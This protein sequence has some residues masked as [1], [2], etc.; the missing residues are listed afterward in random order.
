MAYSLD[1]DITHSFPLPTPEE[2]LLQLPL[3]DQLAH[4]VQSSRHEVRD[5]LNGKSA[6]KLIIVG[7]CSV[8][9]PEAVL[10]YASRLHQLNKELSD[11]FFILM[12]VYCEK[13]RTNLAWKGFLYDP[14]LDGSNDLIFGL[15]VSRE[16]ML[17]ITQM[18]V[19]IAVEFLEPLAAYYYSDLVSWGSIGARTSSSQI[20]RQLASMLPM[21]IGFKNSTEGN[22]ETALAGLIAS[23][24]P[25]RFMGINPK[26]VISCITSKGNPDSHLVL[27]GSQWKHNYDVT[28]VQRV[29]KRLNELNIQKRFIIDCAHGNALG[30]YEN[31]VVAFNE[32]VDQMLN[33]SSKIAGLALESFLEPSK[34]QLG[35]SLDYGVSITDPCL[36]WAQTE[37]LL[38]S[39]ADAFRNIAARQDDYC[40]EPRSVIQPSISR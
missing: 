10:D 29:E 40:F 35:K 23:W 37:F 27:R 3:S 18:H 25:Q 4:F 16:L 5:I 19:P 21:P 7:P 34:Q 24:S 33:P 13:S 17:Q 30:G 38:R 6:K 22:V 14:A 9:D 8:H 32:V 15:Q 26:G 28:S 31:Q 11:Q 36:G 1:L 39:A 2:I 20:H 12:R